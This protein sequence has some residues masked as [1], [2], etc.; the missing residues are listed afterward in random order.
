MTF[1]ENA[2]SPGDASVKS[3]VSDPLDERLGRDGD[4][5]GWMERF[6]QKGIGFYDVLRCFAFFLVSDGE[7]WFLSLNVSILMFRPH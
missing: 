1:N 3:V 7:V 6:L 2:P 4:G 5:K